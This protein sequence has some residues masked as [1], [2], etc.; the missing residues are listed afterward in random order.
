MLTRSL[1]RTSTIFTVG[2]DGS[3]QGIDLSS[4]IGTAHS[5]LGRPG[6]QGHDDLPY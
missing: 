4:A 5:Q 3:I 1:I 2:E 6:F